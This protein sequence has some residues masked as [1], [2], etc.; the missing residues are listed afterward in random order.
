MYKKEKKES[1]RRSKIHFPAH[2]G[3]EDSIITEW[4]QVCLP[5]PGGGHQEVSGDVEERR[6]GDQSII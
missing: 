3:P 6:K 2:F 4:M 5:L 1:E